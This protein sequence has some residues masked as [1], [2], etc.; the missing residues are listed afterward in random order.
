MRARA[1]CAGLALLVSLGFSACLRADESE[2]EYPA[3][4]EP[5]FI[6][7]KQAPYEQPF[8]IEEQAPYEPPFII[9]EPAPSGG[10]GAKSYLECRHYDERGFF[11]AVERAEPYQMEGEMLAAASPH[12]LP[13]MSFTADI[14]STLAREGPADRTVF[15]VAPNHSGEGLPLI[16]ADRGWTTPFG[17]LELDGDAAAAIM[18]SPYLADKIDVDLIHLQGDHSAATVMP[19]IKYYLPEA[20]VV[21][22]MLGR[23][24]PL[25]QLDALAATIYETGRARANQVF[26]LASVDFSHYLRIDETAQ[27]DE[28]TDALIQ[29]GDI[30][31][32]KNLDDGNMDSPE[33]IIALINY[34][35]FFPGAQVER[36]GHVILPESEIE[37]G[38]GYSYSSYIYLSKALP[39]G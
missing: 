36:R 37:P 21:T 13:A 11:K 32:I 38:I 24:C 39:S 23:D 16:V 31:A 35:A 34:A 2:Q 18:N 14:L 8:I 5:P 29:A 10:A 27:R 22:I 4:Y 28:V 15:V 26:L 20:R 33:S 7:E 9:E 25:E 12:F 30:Q 17:N 19:F 3:P 6:I 1:L